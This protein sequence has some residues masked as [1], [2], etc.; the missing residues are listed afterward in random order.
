MRVRI[1]EGK[2][3]GEVFAPPSK[4]MAHR[5]LICSAFAEGDSHIKGISLCDDALATIDCLKNMGAQV[6]VSD[7]DVCIR[8]K[9][10]L[11]AVP[12]G[13]FNCRES[14]S[15]IRFLIPAATLSE[16]EATFCGAESLLNRPMSIYEEIYTSQGLEFSRE[17]NKI[18]AKGR[19]KA[20]EYTLPGNVSSQFITGLMLSLPL[21]DKD[22]VIRVS[23][24][25]ESSSYVK[26]TA[27]AQEAFGVYTTI[28]GNEIRITGGSAYRPANVTTEAD[29]S[30]AAFIDALNY[31]GGQVKIH[32]LKENS[33]QGD[34]VY[35]EYF[36]ILKQGYA[37]LDISDCPDLGPILFALAAAL[38]GGRFTGTRR[39]K[40][41]ESDRC[42]AM[43]QE[44]AKL[45]VTVSVG[46]DFVEV[47]GGISSPAEPLFG[48]ND[49]RI[50]MALSIL[51]TT[52][53]GEI[54]GAEAIKKSY[55]DFF[56]DLSKLG[57]GVEF[58]E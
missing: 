13:E 55:P 33:A 49:H 5:L 45:G 52:V 28:S 31:L 39:L 7:T 22:S 1:T 36:P 42:E 57:I 29:Y 20:G 58:Y 11:R 38:H 41:K 6:T 25:F 37:T 50:V 35:K 10:P 26:L 27:D 12:M 17:G 3:F 23:E 16:N 19:L 30:G 51:L 14:G 4:S 18:R 53:G 34:R 32:G 46:A 9:S 47:S 56:K 54:E 24:P 44:L 48:Y 15:T 43:R 8:G 2:A 21:L 40:I